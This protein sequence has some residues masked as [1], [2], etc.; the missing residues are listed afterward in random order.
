MQLPGGFAAARQ[1]PLLR[2]FGDE[3]PEELADAGLAGHFMDRS[4]LLQAA[5][6]QLRTVGREQG[7]AVGLRD[8]AEQ[9]LQ[10]VVAFQHL[11]LVVE[12]QGR[13]RIGG[14]QRGDGEGAGGEADQSA[15]QFADPAQPV[16]RFAAA[17]DQQ[18]AV[19]PVVQRQG[20]RHS[21]AHAGAF[22]AAGEPAW[23]PAQLRQRQLRPLLQGGVQFGVAGLQR[24]AE[25]GRQVAAAERFVGPG[26]GLPAQVQAADHARPFVAQSTQGGGAGRQGR[27]LADQADQGVQVLHGKP[28]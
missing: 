1:H 9:G 6:D 19:L 5:A 26:G 18:Q 10:R 23:Q 20:E 13:Q 24:I 21:L 25:A 2:R 16:A 8:F 7:G 14:E 28:C 3:G 22:E 27:L 12:Q 15:E 17:F 11:R 4:A